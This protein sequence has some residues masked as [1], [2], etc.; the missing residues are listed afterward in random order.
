MTLFLARF[1]D[2]PD[3]I[4]EVPNNHPRELDDFAAVVEALESHGFDSEP[5]MVA[6]IPAGHFAAEIYWKGEE[7]EGGNPADLSDVGVLLEPIGEKLA[8]WLDELPE[9]EGPSSSGVEVADDEDEDED[10]DEE[11][12]SPA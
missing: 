8:P 4:V 3:V 1:E 9:D 10:V 12:G 2:E 11:E 5:T 6:P 7:I